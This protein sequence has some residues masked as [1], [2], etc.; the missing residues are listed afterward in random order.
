MAR[1]L[2]PF[3][4]PADWV[5]ELSAK[6][7]VRYGLAELAAAAVLQAAEQR[8]ALREYGDAMVLARVA[9]GLAEFQDAEIRERA[10]STTDKCLQEL[11]AG[12]LSD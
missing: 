9:A 7:G 5:P 2:G 3:S 4:D 10:E 12:E 11:P 1:R 8:A 6:V